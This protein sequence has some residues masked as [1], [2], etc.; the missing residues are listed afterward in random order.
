MSFAILSLKYLL[1]LALF[2]RDMRIHHKD[3]HFKV[4][5][6]MR[7]FNDLPNVSH[8]KGSMIQFQL[9]TIVIIN[10]KFKETHTFIL[11]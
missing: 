3:T 6:T 7:C 5:V 11:N 8:T 2:S 9:N 1:S 4:L 10:R